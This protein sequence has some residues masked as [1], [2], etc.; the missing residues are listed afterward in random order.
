MAKAHGT[1][2]LWLTELRAEGAAFAAAVGEAD[3]A[4]PVPSCPGWTVADLV[5]HLG[6]TYRWVHTHAVRGVTVKPDRDLAAFAGESHATDPLAWW[7]EQ[8]STLL[9]TLDVLDPDLPAWNWA[10][11]AKRAAF[12][13]RRMAH[14][15]S[16][17]R[18]DAQMAIGGVE[19]IETRLAADGIAEVLDSWLPAGRRLGPTDRSGMVALRAGDIEHVWYVR[20]RGAG[21][22]LLDTDTI[23]DDDDPKAR[24]V[25]SGSASD[26]L[27]ALWGRVG[28][29]VLDVTGDETLLSALRVGP[30]STSDQVGGLIRTN[31]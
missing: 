22:A 2:E 16:V 14:E 25:A 4:A 27:L 8:Y 31:P 10:P 9:T 13:H 28:F 17:H 3:M 7:N 24:V 12:W 18:W 29:D 26:L 15:T 5:D 6:T 23:F 20:L 30:A 1:K 19:P 21:V 11:R